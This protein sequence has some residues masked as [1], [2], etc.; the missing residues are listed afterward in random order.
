MRTTDEI[1]IC[2]IDGKLGRF[3]QSW[4]NWTREMDG[5]FDKIGV[6]GTYKTRARRGGR[7][8]VVFGTAG[9]EE[10]VG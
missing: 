7:Y 10:R 4:T 5:S 9:G 6:G 2:D 3:V 1:T 8:S